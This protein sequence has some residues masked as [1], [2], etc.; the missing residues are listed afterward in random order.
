MRNSE[1][2]AVVLGTKQE[3]IPMNKKKTETTPNH[4]RGQI[5]S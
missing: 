5:H 4:I 3:L 1:N 2:I